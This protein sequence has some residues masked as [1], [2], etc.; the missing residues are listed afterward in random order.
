M[1]MSCLPLASRCRSAGGTPA[2][3]ALRRVRLRGGLAASGGTPAHR[4][5]LRFRL[6]FLRRH[7]LGLFL[8][9]DLGLLFLV[10]LLVLLLVLGGLGLLLFDGLALDGLRLLALGGLGLLALGGLGRLDDLAFL[11]ASAPGPGLLLA[12]L[13]ER[14]KA[15]E[16]GL[17]G[18]P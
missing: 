17:Q 11:D 16:V 8:R 4:L 12:Q 5:R 7:G 14:L 3:G 2:G 9:D 10:A 15:H 1:A 18:A 13:D 6:L